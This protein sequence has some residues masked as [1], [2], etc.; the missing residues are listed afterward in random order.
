[1]PFTSEYKL[2]DYRVKEHKVP[3]FVNDMNCRNLNPS[4]NNITLW[5]IFKT[6][7]KASS[8]LFTVNKLFLIIQWLFKW[9]NKKKTSSAILLI[10]AFLGI[11]SFFVALVLIGLL[12][13]NP[14]K[15]I[16][17]CD[18]PKKTIYQSMEL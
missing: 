9:I 18:K 13:I 10:S 4:P 14:L 16:L 6:D 17:V 3:E 15:P 8:K 7:K 2:I 11:M 1:M 12:C 5:K